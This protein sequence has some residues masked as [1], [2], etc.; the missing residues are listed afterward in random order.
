MY[1]TLKPFLELCLLNRG[2]QDLPASAA[3]L[4]LTTLGYFAVGAAVAWPVYEPAIAVATAGFDV[5]LLFGVTAGLLA[6]RGHRG[7]W[8]QTTTALAGSG[9]LMGL[10]ALPIVF[11]VYRAILTQSDATF[12]VLVY[13]VLV[14]WIIAIY[15]HVCTQA[16]S[17]RSRWLGLGVALGYFVLSWVSMQLVFPEGQL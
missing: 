3:L 12:S 7:R 6:W 5:L 16:L 2:P 17:L 14:G 8:L 13:W 1:A 4:L 15:G 10:I 11:S 9:F